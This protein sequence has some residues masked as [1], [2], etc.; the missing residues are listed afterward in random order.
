MRRES[1]V[2]FCEGAGGQFPRATRRNI[3]VRSERAGH[4]VMA[5]VV[6]FIETKLRLKVNRDKSAV[7]RPR[8]RHFV[9]FHLRG[10]EESGEPEVLPSKRSKDRLAAKVR[11]LT[12][13]SWGQAVTDC[14]T[15]INAYLIGWMAF[16]GV[17]SPTPELARLLH[18]IDAHIR[19]RLRA[20]LLRQW[21]RKRFIARRLIR[22]GARPV[23]AWRTL[24]QGRKSL[25]ALS[26][27]A[28]VDHALDNNYF[29]AQGLASLEALYRAQPR[30][31]QRPQPAAQPAGVDSCGR[32]SRR[33]PRT[34]IELPRT[35][36]N[37]QAATLVSEHAD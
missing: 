30:L 2:R 12:P 3:Y 5:S 4:R 33:R 20:L 13:R 24:Y 25:W 36:T 15:R 26:H 10:S 16:F 28:V 9:G 7:A 32:Q 17:C 18:N 19:R 21:K 37:G 14:I 22:L 1:H 34:R 6:Q 23:T 8:E 27:C 11:Q 31:R 35:R 29:A